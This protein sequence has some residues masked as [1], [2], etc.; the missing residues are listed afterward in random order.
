MDT[1][2]H[3]LRTIVPDGGTWLTWLIQAALAVG[4]V[5]LIANAISGVLAAIPVVGPTLA[6]ITK[7]IAGRYQQ[8]LTD[9]VPKLA[10]QAVLTV[11]ER[12]RTA[13]D[14]PPDQRAAQKMQ[15]ALAELDKL[16]PGLKRDTAKS[17]L[18]AALARIRPHYEQK[19]AL[20]PKP[21]G[22]RRGQ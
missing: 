9:Q 12:Y 17:A 19:A 15:E 11:E 1:I 16:A 8:W 5:M 2:T 3:I 21:S 7:I 20:T 4:V 18:E 14:I 22:G 10:E 6:T 13:E